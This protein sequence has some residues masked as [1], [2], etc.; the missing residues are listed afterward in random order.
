MTLNL[1][2]CRIAVVGLGYVGLPLA[3]EFGRHFD[4]TGFDVKAARVAALRKGRDTTL[5][6]S[7]A[8]FHDQFARAAA[9]PGVH[10]HGAHAD[11]R[12]QAA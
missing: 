11:R 12:L 9:L 1:R 5:E 6:V 10:R 4:T 3:V 7:R 2:Q 8:E